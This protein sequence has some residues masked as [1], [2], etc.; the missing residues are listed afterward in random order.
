MYKKI[1]YSFLILVISF[2]NLKADE[3]NIAVG[4]GLG[5]NRG[6]NEG[7]QDERTI[8]PL[9]SAFGIFNNGILWGLSPEIG[10]SYYQNGTSDVEGGFSQYKTSYIVPELRLRYSL[11]NN[12]VWKPYIFGGVGAMIYN[13]DNNVPFNRD[14]LENSGVTVA[15]PV[16]AGVGYQFDYNWGLDLSAGLH[17]TLT[18]NLNP[19]Y[20][21]INDGNWI[22][23][24]GVHYVVARFSPDSDG[25]GLTDDEER[26]LGT[27]PNNPDTDGDGLLDGEEVKKY[28][29]DPLNPDTDGGGVNDGIEVRNGAN[30]LDPDD[31]ILN[32]GVG[33]RI[34]MKNIEFA[35]GKSEINPTSEKILNNALNAMNKMTNTTFEIVGHTDDVGSREN[36]IQL[37]LERANAVKKWLVDR[38]VNEAR[39]TTRG[40]GPDEPIVA[41]TNAEN[42]QRN[43]RVEFFRTK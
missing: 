26:L 27:D 17:L 9:F 3:K 42:R 41:N 13:I 20:D 28:K 4:V 38:G 14:F 36:N 23:R 7:I 22:A 18:D 10:I 19:V 15:F 25:D 24:L 31:D 5:L 34:I 11:G 30:P 21:D 40:A 1:I 37:S 35:T 29:T 6:I 43:R 33:E 39:L 32:I 16:G 12:L 8:G 2:S